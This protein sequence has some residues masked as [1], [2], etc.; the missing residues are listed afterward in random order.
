MARLRAR[1][2]DSST[3]TGTQLQCC[4]R[5]LLQIKTKEHDAAM[6]RDTSERLRVSFT[7]GG[8]AFRPRAS[9]LRA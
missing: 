1:S 8:G 6:R 5:S 9:R 2:W 4:A 3:A 7:A